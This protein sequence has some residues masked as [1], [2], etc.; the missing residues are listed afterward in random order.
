MIIKSVHYY[1]QQFTATSRMLTE[2]KEHN[3]FTEQ[4]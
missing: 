1:R 3:E 4:L 2:E